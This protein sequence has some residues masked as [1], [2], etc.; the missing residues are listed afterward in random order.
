MSPENKI[1]FKM[2]HRTLVIRPSCFPVESLPVDP[3]REGQSK[4]ARTTQPAAPIQAIPRQSFSTRIPSLRTTRAGRQEKTGAVRGEI[5]AFDVESVVPEGAAHGRHGEGPVTPGLRTEFPL[6]PGVR[7]HQRISNPQP[8]ATHVPDALP[9]ACLTRFWLS[10]F[11]KISGYLNSNMTV[12]CCAGPRQR[13][14][15]CSA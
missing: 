5:S 12:S 11:L 10:Q 6:P 1:L 7:W 15:A 3:R 13:W 4:R 8:S 2:T 9:R 14:Q